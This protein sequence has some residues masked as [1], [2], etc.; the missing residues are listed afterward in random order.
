MNT[1]VCESAE[2]AMSG[3][4][5]HLRKLILL[6]FFLSV[7][8]YPARLNLFRCPREASQSPIFL[9]RPRVLI[10]AEV[11]RPTR[12]FVLIS[13]HLNSDVLFVCYASTCVCS[14]DV[15]TLSKS[16]QTAFS[17]SVGRGEII[18]V[19]SFLLSEQPASL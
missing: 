17:L 9:G 14:S 13:F 8:V 15:L 2:I 3:A 18:S 11:H 7:A 1:W 12:V 19:L 5:M 16:K 10:S 6:G 4:E